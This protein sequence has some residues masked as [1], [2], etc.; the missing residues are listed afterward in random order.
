ML[1]QGASAGYNEGLW[2]SAD[3]F[4]QDRATFIAQMT[5]ISDFVDKQMNFATADSV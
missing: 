3:I 1:G 2:P 4:N 5:I